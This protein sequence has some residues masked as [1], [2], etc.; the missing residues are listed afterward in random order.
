MY[1]DRWQVN[2]VEFYDNNFFVSEA[3]T[4]EFAERIAPLKIRWWGEARIDT[5]LKYSPRSW[6]LMRDSGLRMVF[7]GAESGSAE[8]L[9]RMDKGGA[10]SPEKTLEIARLMREHGIVPEF[11][12]VLGNPPDPE[13]DIRHTLEFIRRVKT[14][15][16]L[17]EIILY[18]YTPVPLA[19]DLYDNAQASGFHFPQTLDEWISP[20]WANFA[21]RRSATLPWMKQPLWDQLRDFERVLNAYYPTATDAKLNGARRTLLRAAS[22]WRYHLR[23]YRFP[24][25]LRALHRVLA[26]QRPET[27]GF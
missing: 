11:S 1:A 23:F 3:R 9:K 15:N 17:A 27:S 8:T 10:L 16:P 6:R 7:M 24:F 2:A 19:G 13:A 14:V 5:L 22:A 18:L 20:T 26:Y 4:A 21:Q 25:E 12:F